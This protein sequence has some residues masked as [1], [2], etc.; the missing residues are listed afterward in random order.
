MIGLDTNVLIR[1]FVGDDPGQ[2][3][4]ARRLMSSLDESRPGFVCREV[5]LE[6]VWVLQRTYRME[7]DRIADALDGLLTAREIVVETAD[8]IAAAVADWRSGGAGLGD[9]MIAAAARRAGAAPLVTF[10]RRAAT[11]PDADLLS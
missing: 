7:R 4:A 8:D 2:T 5:V 1:F 3:E 6:T 11:L 10:D 9:R